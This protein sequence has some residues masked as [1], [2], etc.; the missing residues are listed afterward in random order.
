[1]SGKIKESSSDRTCVFGRTKM[2]ESSCRIFT[3]V[4]LPPGGI[5]CRFPSGEVWRTKRRSCPV[6][7]VSNPGPRAIRVPGSL[8]G[9]GD[10]SQSAAHES[11][12]VFHSSE[13]ALIAANEPQ[14]KGAVR[15]RVAGQPAAMLALCQQTP[16]RLFG[17]RRVAAVSARASGR[18]R[19]AQ[20]VLE[21]GL[22]Q[23]DRAQF[24][25]VDPR[26]R[27]VI[28]NLL[29]A[30]EERREV[31][32]GLESQL[33]AARWQLRLQEPASGERA[34]YFALG[35]DLEQAW[36]HEM[37]PRHLKIRKKYCRQDTALSTE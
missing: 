5:E 17:E 21:E 7:F 30:W 8:S 11:S 10:P 33:E 6:G 31:V 19:L 20:L 24:E 14:V 1:M 13:S 15:W 25:V 27:N 3:H 23:M 2:R 18:T 29:R 16:G 32:R 35:A 26:N 12:L 9:E 4:S 37:S 36:N 28:G 22:F 34:A